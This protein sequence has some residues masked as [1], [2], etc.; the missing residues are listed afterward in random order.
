M[1]IQRETNIPLSIVVATS[2]NHA[3]GRDGDLP[4]RLS[5]DLKWFKKVTS[6]KPVIMGRKTFDSLGKALPNR[7]NIV[8]T[9]NSSFKAQNVTVATNL[10]DAIRIAEAFSLAHDT[11]EICIIGGGEIYRQAIEVA[12]TIYITKVDCL[13]EDADTFFPAI[14]MSNWQECLVQSISKNEK[15]DHDAVVM[16]LMRR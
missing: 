16:K 15:N 8:I 9:R 11:N 5:D 14:D 6:G 7:D 10:E 4:W 3:S 2:K 12:N 1:T 13:V